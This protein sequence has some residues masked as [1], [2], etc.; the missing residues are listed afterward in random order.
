[1]DPIT[2]AKYQNPDGYAAYMNKQGQTIDP[3]RNDGQHAHP[4]AHIPLW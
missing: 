1:M 2:S 4:S 3:A